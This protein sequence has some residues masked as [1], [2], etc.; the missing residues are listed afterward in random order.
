[1]IKQFYEKALPT[2]G[3]YCASGI[4]KTG[5][6]TNRFAETFDDLL[7]IIEKLKASDVNIFVTPGTFEGFSRKGEDSVFFRSFFIDLD[8]GPEK[9]YTTK[10]AAL[11]ALDNFVK[12]QTLPQPVRLDSGTGVHAYWIFDRDIPT[13]EWKP[14]AERFKKLC[15]D[16]IAIDPVVTADAARLMRSPGTLNYKTDPPSPT[17]LLDEEIT[18]HN[19]DAFCQQLLAIAPS[20]QD[21]LAD[22]FASIPKGLDDDTLHLKKLDNFETRF[23]ILGEASVNDE[24]CAQ[25]KYALLNAKTLDYDTWAGMLSLASK[26]D[27]MEDAIRWVSE[28]H[29]DYNYDSAY[30]KALTFDSVTSCN[31]FA[32]H[33][34]ERC[35]GCPHKGHITNPLKL[36]RRLK[37]IPAQEKPNTDTVR[38]DADPTA[39]PEF[40]QFLWPYVRGVNGGIYF[41]PA[42][43]TTKEG[44]KIQDDPIKLVASDV[45][46]IKRMYSPL[47]GDCLLMKNVLPRDAP[48]EFLVPM[49]NAYS[50]DELSKAMS[51]NGVLYEPNAINH[52]KGYVVKWGQYLQQTKS[53]EQMRMQF[54][55]TE[56]YNGFVLGDQEYRRD[57]TVVKTAI[58]PY[59]KELGKLFK[60]AGSYDKWKEAAQLLNSPSLEIHAFAMLCAFASPLMH[61]TST[62]GVTISFAAEPGSGK[63]GAM[64]A[65]L[66]TFANPKELCV[67]DSTDNALLQRCLGLHNLMFGL[68]E[69]TNKDAEQLAHLIHRVSHGKAKV[70]MQSSVNAERTM[71]VS[72][73]LIAMLTTNEEVMSILK[74]AKAN[75]DGESARVVEFSLTKPEILERDPS[76]GERIFD[77]FRTNYG[78]AFPDFIRQVYKVG[79]A[80]ILARG[81]EWQ[82]R[83]KK[84]FTDD[85]TFRFYHNL[86][87][88]TM[89]AGELINEAAIVKLDLERIYDAVV[90]SILSVR[91]GTAKKISFDYSNLLGEFLNQHHTGMLILNGDK[92]VQEPRTALVARV[93]VHNQMTYVSKKIFSEYLQKHRLSTQRFELELK[94][95]DVKFVE[96]K[97]RL[98]K[99][100]KAGMAASTSTIQVYGFPGDIPAEILDNDSGT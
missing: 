41:M 6:T 54:G 37:V 13:S 97:Q 86:I 78:W 59:V 21:T 47:D 66:S 29:K 49:K 5:K 28:G 79:N 27:D 35:E 80:H 81:E 83:F 85:T 65:G 38:E 25:V 11:D 84:D 32:A 43:K 55:W 92:I 73:S 22:I 46:A 19:F 36:A 82:T 30:K 90:L 34:P 2:Q 40:P 99:G 48:R 57:G 31:T 71:E 4:T 39:I 70:R 20:T 100:W 96:I 91:H 67:F 12:T 23:E 7:N 1:M 95:R 15:L 88:V 26:C 69:V 24:G 77:V 45:F 98:S 87:G 93:E 44:K 75:P 64:Y 72:A 50:P 94:K 42:P 18:V 52:L 74:S 63:T 3:V 16:Y 17:K 62:S 33:H 89:A 14:Q 60:P 51:A 53:A 8:V 76:M 10:E 68:D 61:L 56:D 9:P 58:S